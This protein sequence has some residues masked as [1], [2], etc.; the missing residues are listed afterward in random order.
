MRL[1]NHNHIFIFFFFFILAAVSCDNNQQK[2]HTPQTANSDS[3][4][5][6]Q[7]SDSI[8]TMPLSSPAFKDGASIPHKF[9]CSGK[10]ISPPLRWTKVPSK[11][12]SLALIV[13][14]PDAPNLIWDHWILFNLPANINQLN[15]HITPENIK[16]KKAKH[17]KNN[18]DQLKYGGPCPPK[19]DGPH[20]YYFK[21][22]ALDTML[23]LDAGVQKK[24]LLQ[25]MENH[26]VA[27]GQLKGTFERSSE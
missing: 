2:S 18:F 23:S 19:G 5:Q 13:E 11:A 12:Q 26:I 25:A 10:D 22:Y 20:T 3:V 8:S 24:Q 4:K 7:Q 9:S 15:A 14:D 17:G 27:Q 21:L 6:T 1:I 16:Y